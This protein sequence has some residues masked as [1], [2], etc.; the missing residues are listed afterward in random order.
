MMGVVVVTTQDLL[1]SYP[2]QNMKK[3]STRLEFPGGDISRLE[4]TL[5]MD[6]PNA[7]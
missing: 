1:K 7:K 3:F 5:I 4:L 6:S 2:Y